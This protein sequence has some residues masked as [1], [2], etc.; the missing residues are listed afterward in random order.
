MP[1]SLK[2]E[3]RDRLYD[4]EGRELAAPEPACNVV[5]YR[6]LDLIARLLS[7][8][9]GIK[10]ILYWAVGEGDPSW[11]A[12]PKTA[13]RNATTLVHEIY[14]K[15]LDLEQEI[16]YDPETH[17]LTVAVTFAPDEAV[18]T[19]REFGLFGGDASPEPDS[20]YLINYRIH[21]A[22][23][24]SA[25]NSLQRTLQFTFS[26]E[27]MPIPLIDLIGELLSNTEGL[28]GI[29]YCAV[30]PGQSAWDT[31]PPPK[32]LNATKLI[33]ESFR[34]RIDPQQQ[35]HYLSDTH[36]L[37][38][39][40]RF[41]FDE[42]EQVLREFGLVGGN[43]TDEPNTGYLL[44]YETHTALNK[45]VLEVLDREFRLTLG[46][47]AD[48]TVPRLQNLTLAQARASLAEARLALGEVSEVESPVLEVPEVISE[49]RVVEQQPVEGEV[50]PEGA[51]VNVTLSSLPKV[52]VPEL[53]GLTFPEAQDILRQ[54]RLLIAREERTEVSANAPG[55]IAFQLPASGTH[56]RQGTKVTVR[57]A[58][59]F[60][61]TVPDLAGLTPEAA[62]ITL[63]QSQLVLA[64][65]PFP[66]SERQ[67]GWDTVMKQQPAAGANAPIGSSV[68][69]TIAVPHTV[70]VPNIVGLDP[71]KAAA[72][73]RA[74]GAELLADLHLPLVPPALSMGAQLRV[75]TLERVGRVI[76]QDPVAQASVPLFSTVQVQVGTL[77]K[78][79]VP[80]V[81]GLKLD[82]ATGKLNELGYQVGQVTRTPNR[83]PA[84][85]VIKQ[86]PEAGTLAEVG[87]KVRLSVA[88]PILVAVPNLVGQSGDL[89]KE[90]LLGLGLALDE[91]LTKPSAEPDGTVLEQ[92]PVAGEKVAIGTKVQLT[93]SK[94]TLPV[95]EAG[96]GFET[97]LGKSFTLDGSGSKPAP[98]K[99]IAKYIWTQFD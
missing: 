83:S 71:E 74:V 92:K 60:L 43:P 79:N 81:V 24:K 2:G 33:S 82:I 65:P 42:A 52:T 66:V 5:V 34:K 86:E 59:P 32:N 97:E 3:Y 77:A 70:E 95:A 27:T 37:L 8:E 91:L 73:L 46:S 68:I 98:G 99:K 18:G 45:A 56:V 35:I 76:S 19:L 9:P 78:N 30:G 61:V 13:D 49:P 80:N 7:N 6:A 96:I 20:G 88:L 44:H 57:L 26:P 15:P 1:L 93:T 85:V 84:N 87:L 10:G 40:V 31:N 39:Q 28:S 53:G 64:S 58:T 4:L 23:E 11:D 55:T 38:V 90:K 47:G 36:T 48:A 17:R 29:Q 21:P 12:D 25:A 67:T 72:R 75:E 89:A 50:V 22:V 51:T 62:S 54:V 63:Q 94:T 41:A 14:R 69:V 16:S